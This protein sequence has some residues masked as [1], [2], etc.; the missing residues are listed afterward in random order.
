MKIFVTGY[1]FTD[2]TL[3]E[4]PKQDWLITASEKNLT[5]MADT[6]YRALFDKM[7]WSEIAEGKTLPCNNFY[8]CRP[9]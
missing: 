3:T 1:S 4:N 6:D 2:Q 8:Q 9:W 7:V 5:L